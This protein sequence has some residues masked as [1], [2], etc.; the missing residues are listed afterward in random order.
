VE[1]VSLKMGETFSK[2]S[3]DRDFMPCT[4]KSFQFETFD[5]KV[6]PSAKQK[7]PLEILQWF[8]KNVHCFNNLT[9]LFLDL[10]WPNE[11]FQCKLLTQNFASGVK[12]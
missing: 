9:Q 7:K 1:E 5:C 2:K 3:S 11:C 4:L 6:F 12:R 10:M 8:D